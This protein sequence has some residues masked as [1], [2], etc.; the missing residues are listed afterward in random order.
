V[1]QGYYPYP[2]SIVNLAYVSEAE[3]DATISRPFDCFT[4]L[5][6]NQVASGSF[7]GAL[8]P[9]SGETDTIKP[10]Y[11]STTSSFVH[12][13]QANRAANSA[14]EG[15]IP[16]S[17]QA[18]LPNNSKQLFDIYVGTTV[19]TA[20]DSLALINQ[21]GSQTFQIGSPLANAS[22]TS[23]VIKDNLLYIYFDQSC[24]G[25]KSLNIRAHAGTEADPFEIAD[26]VD[27][28]CMQRLVNEGS[29]RPG[30][31]ILYRH[32]AW[33]KLTADIT[34]IGTWSGI[35]TPTASFS[36]KFYGGKT[37]DPTNA[38]VTR[39]LTGLT[40]NNT[41]AS[42]DN[43]GLFGVTNGDVSISNVHLGVT[44]TGR[45]N[46]GGLIG[47]ATGNLKIRSVTVAGT[48]SATTYVGAMVGL[49]MPEG[50]TNL[51]NYDYTISDT[52]VA[53]N[54]TAQNQAGGF[55]GRKTSGSLLIA[56]SS[57]DGEI[58]CSSYDCA[59]FLAYNN[60]TDTNIG[61]ARFYNVYA[62]GVAWTRAAGGTIGSIIA[63]NPGGAN[64]LI[65]NAHS[66]MAINPSS[67]TYS[68]GLSIY[69]GL[70]GGGV[71]LT[72][73]WWIILDSTYSTTQT[74]IA[75]SY[76]GGLIGRIGSNA[77]TGS[78]TPYN[79]VLIQN[80]TA[81]VNIMGTSVQLTS[82]SATDFGGLIGGVVRAKSIRIESSTHYGNLFGRRIVGGIIGE[83]YSGVP[84]V[85]INNVYHSGTIS[86]TATGA[87]VGIGLGGTVGVSFV[88]LTITN[89]SASGLIYTGQN[90]SIDSRT[91]RV[92]QGLGGIV[93]WL[94]HPSG[95]TSIDNVQ[96]SGTVSAAVNTT[97]PT[98]QTN[99]LGGVI[100]TVYR[101]SIKVTNSVNYGTITNG[102]YSAGIVGMV[103]DGYEGSTSPIVN[104][105]GMTFTFQNVA[106]YGNV[107]SGFKSTA[108]AYTEVAGG[109]VGLIR[110]TATYISIINAINHGSIQ[111]GNWTG[112]VIGAVYFNDN[113]PN[114]NVGTLSRA[115]NSG[116]VWGV[117]KAGGM[118]GIMN[119][120]RW[121]VNNVI[122]LSRYTAHYA[123][124]SNYPAAGSDQYRW[125]GVS[126][127][128]STYAPF[129]NSSENGTGVDC[130]QLK[131]ITF[132][133][134]NMNMTK[135][136]GWNTDLVPYG[137]MPY[138]ENLP[139]RD[140]VS[141][142]QPYSC[143]TRLTTNN[144][145][146]GTIVAT[147]S[148]PNLP[149]S[150]SSSAWV[151]YYFA[152]KILNPPSYQVNPT[153]TYQLYSMTSS[154]V[155]GTS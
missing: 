105:S 82:D 62:S 50:A 129:S 79:N 49:T 121:A 125:N 127:S 13:Y 17:Y 102:R 100:G 146:S 16:P 86:G 110:T 41:T 91:G 81:S 34:S 83:I 133:E 96:F 44:I 52:K 95:T 131:D 5:S 126:S 56:N 97:S 140:D 138:L 108:T 47:Q 6:T 145:A 28:T 42:G 106:N 9:V 92:G 155:S 136:T 94:G 115:V 84:S 24:G 14:L 130:A 74:M 149:V 45:N 85:T 68:A 20:T 76:A 109:I 89:A 43:K 21:S 134:T 3:R 39:T 88:P 107:T 60:G 119:Y 139:Y 114:I 124:A 117:Q 33:W 54:I 122:N 36:G 144:V 19:S 90:L 98:Y 53:V 64:F 30:S 22:F 29:P 59:G 67:K 132:W 120:N 65:E 23:T 78:D 128:T 135:A 12:Y 37:N 7:G 99:G 58:S 71:S 150:G 73:S 123:T 48:I 32:S 8:K 113:L 25:L 26:L 31:T 18:T 11:A 142:S 118:Y 61:E 148:S 147:D 80:S 75:Q 70:V 103:C 63:Y 116:S 143:M 55:V 104:C 69:G 137:Y 40:F 111:G 66:T 57:Y 151:N 27:L 15:L 112:G 72:S 4:Q 87:G 154:P 10:N 77:I 46:V 2:K 153:R 51:S 101:G 93:G 35:G 141:I 152:S 38:D 1:T